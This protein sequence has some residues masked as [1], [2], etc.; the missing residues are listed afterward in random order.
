[1]A[2]LLDILRVIWVLFSGIIGLSGRYFPLITWSTL[3][4]SPSRSPE[5]GNPIKHRYRAAPGSL[6]N[7]KKAFLA[8]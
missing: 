5:R 8:D 6:R 7:N 1:M 3:A 2:I 4:S